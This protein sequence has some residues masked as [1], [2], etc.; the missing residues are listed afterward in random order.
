MRIQWHFKNGCGSAGRSCAR[1]CLKS[2]PVRSARF[3]EMN[4]GV[5]HAG[6]DRQLRRVDL[7]A[8]A[9]AKVRSNRRE[10]SVNNCEITLASAHEQIEVTHVVCSSCFVIPTGV[11]ES[12]TILT[13]A[14]L[15][16]DKRCLDFARHDK[17]SRRCSPHP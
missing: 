2:F 12:L 4:M 1:T 11:E 7:F 16:N 17:M 15:A 5:D 6:K 10:L 14:S 9:A 13:L 3:V 8:R